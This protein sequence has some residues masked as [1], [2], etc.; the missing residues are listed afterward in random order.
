MRSRP[1]LRS[2]PLAIAASLISRKPELVE[3]AQRRRQLPRPAVDQH[4]IG[5]GPAFGEILVPRKLAETPCQHLPH[6]GVIVPGGKVLRAHIEL[7]ILIADE[8]FRA[9]HD[10]GADRIGAG[11]VA[12]VEHLDALRALLQL[13]QLGKPGKDR[14]LRG[15][16]GKPP[17]RDFA[18]VH[19]GMRHELA[20]LAALRG[21][22]PDLV[23]RAQGQGFGKQ[24]PS[25][26]LV[27]QQ[28]KLRRRL[29]VI[30]LGN[31]GFEHLFHRETLVGAGKVRAVAPIVAGAEEEHLDR[32]L[33]RV[34]MG[35]EHI[36][37]LHGLRIDA[38][39]RLHVAER[40]Q[41]VAETRRAL[42]VLLEAR[43]VH[44]SVHAPFHLVAFAGEEAERFI[45]EAFIVM[46]RYFAGAGR[47]AA[48][49]LKEQ[50]RPHARL[51]IGVGA[52][53]QQEGALKRVDGAPDG[54]SRS[55]RSEIISLPAPR[56]AMLEDLREGMVARDE[57]EGKG[58][59][60]P[61]HHIVAGLQPLDEIG[62]EQQ[63]LGLARRGDEFHARGVGDHRGDAVVVA[64]RPRIALHALLQPAR[65]ADIKHLAGGIDHAIDA[66]AAGRGLGMTG[67]HGRSRLH[68]AER[69]AGAGDERNAVGFGLL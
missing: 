17:R 61:E 40:G 3:H 41:P 24:S 25:G 50:A 28:Y 48:L 46:F 19:E 60:V 65:L 22:D 39:M 44:Q 29:V 32:G 45:D 14:R 62:L 30:E 9:C 36:R 4:E 42:I 52:R 27:R 56:A 57:D 10:H 13:E 51:E 35:G 5:R 15:G 18:R 68:A 21:L 7:P 59:V 69:L 64:L 11:N 12:V 63:R 54:A 23:A 49:D 33:P 38:L 20:L 6:H 31:E 1:A 55:E 67:D 8:P 34:L 47:A 37:I 66:G 26:N 58:L 43:I 53:S 2:G 16:L